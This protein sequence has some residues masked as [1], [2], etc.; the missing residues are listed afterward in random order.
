LRRSISLSLRVGFGRLIG[1]ASNEIISSVPAGLETLSS[2]LMKSP[3]S[4]EQRP[5]TPPPSPN[6]SDQTPPLLNTV[7][8]RTLRNQRIKRL[9]SVRQSVPRRSSLPSPLSPLHRRERSR[10][11]LFPEK[12]PSPEELLLETQ[13]RALRE[14]QNRVTKLM[15]WVSNMTISLILFPHRQGPGGREL[16]ISNSAIQLSQVPGELCVCFSLSLLTLPG[17]AIDRR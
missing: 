2:S 15:R 16:E 14:M 9:R 12:E 10:R 1:R 11:N 3:S 5:S 6:S 17:L 7:S 4:T 8:R 13:A